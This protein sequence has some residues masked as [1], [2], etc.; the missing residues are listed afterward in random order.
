MKLGDMIRVKYPSVSVFR[1]EEMGV[2]LGANQ[3]EFTILFTS[4]IV[5]HGARAYYCSYYEVVS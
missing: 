5:N 2:I 4:G 1:G 3:H